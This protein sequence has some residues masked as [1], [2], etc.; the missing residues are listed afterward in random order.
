M[1]LLSTNTVYLCSRPGAPRWSDDRQVLIF[2]IGLC[3]GA[4]P[5]AEAD[6]GTAQL[7]GRTG[8]V[9]VARLPNPGVLVK[10]W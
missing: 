2:K 9:Q 7:S 4:D 1:G 6:P 3:L 8:G 10:P 5:F